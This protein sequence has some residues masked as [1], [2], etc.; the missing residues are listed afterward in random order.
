MAS[1]GNGD[2]RGVILCPCGAEGSIRVGATIFGR[3]G[4]P[5]TELQHLLKLY[6]AYFHLL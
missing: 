4:G 1:N 5:V 2:G 3:C 6:A